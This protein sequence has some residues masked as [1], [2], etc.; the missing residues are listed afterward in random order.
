MCSMLLG[1]IGSTAIAVLV[2][3][4]GLTHHGTLKELFHSFLPQ[5]VGPAPSGL[6]DVIYCECNI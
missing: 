5:W 2:P 3:G 6:A 1:V 4:H